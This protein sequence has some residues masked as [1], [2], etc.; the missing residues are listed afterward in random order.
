MSKIVRLPCKECI[1]LA[2]C[3]TKEFINCDNLFYML[4]RNFCNHIYINLIEQANNLFPN[5]MKIKDYNKGYP[6][7]YFLN[8]SIEK[9]L[10]KET[11]G[12]G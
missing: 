2:I 3:K 5:A 1:L 7:C 11:Y 4:E 12:K 8:N 6:Y 9:R 10:I